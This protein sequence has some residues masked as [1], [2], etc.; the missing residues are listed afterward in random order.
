VTASRTDGAR[1]RTE[2]AAAIIGSVRNQTPFGQDNQG[3]PI[4]YVKRMKIA[5]WWRT[6]TMADSVHG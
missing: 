4:R 1:G 5:I 2:W 3:Q 6:I